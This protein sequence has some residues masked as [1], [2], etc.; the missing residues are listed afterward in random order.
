MDT[1]NKVETLQE[2]Q[3]KY[4]FLDFDGVLH[5]LSDAYNNQEFSHLNVLDLFVK[6]AIEKN[7]ICINIVVFI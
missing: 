2:L 4:I 1:V 6:N 7:P 5:T 3:D